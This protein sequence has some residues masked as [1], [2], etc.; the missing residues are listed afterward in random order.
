MT[1]EAP[2]RVLVTGAGGMLAHDLVPALEAAGHVVTGAKRA[3]LD[4]TDPSACARAVAGHGLVVNT[5]AWTAVDDAESNEP[6]AFA[7]N[8]VAAANVARAAAA[9]GAR[10][11]H[12]STDYVFDG[13][14]TEP[15]AADSPVCPRSAYGR[16][17][18]AGEWAVRALCPQSWVVRTAWLYGAGGPNFVETMTR[19]SQQRETVSVVDDQIGQPTWT[20]DLADLIV[21][22]V[23]S[24]AQ[25]GTYHGTSRG[26]VSWF[27]FTRAIFEDLGLDPER[28]RP[29]TT[30]AFPRPARRPAWSVL[31][32]GSLEAAGV[33]P[34][35]DWRDAI[36]AYLSAE[37][38]SA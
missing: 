31:S 17:K 8:A 12:I 32:H 36:G 22:L 38:R 9:V 29:T 35:R 37:A 16:T 20:V 5:A 24:S 21:R 28:V 26:R 6:A 11:V 10:M 3:D 13:Q 15:Y 27:G 25:Y 34:I 18:A 7:I 30:E 2:L 4:I 14:A 1:A 19:L 33:S 23:G